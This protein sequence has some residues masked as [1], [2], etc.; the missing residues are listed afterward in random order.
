M[1]LEAVNLGLHPLYKQ[2]TAIPSLNFLG[3]VELSPYYPSSS[4]AIH[5][6]LE[7][8]R[9]DLDGVV[10]LFLPFG[11]MPFASNEQRL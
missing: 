10:I 7:I 9:R 1:K 6:A 3:G 11:A 4:L 8:P 5:I 2:P